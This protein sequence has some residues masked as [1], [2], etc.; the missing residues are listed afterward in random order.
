MTVSP[1]RASR[2]MSVDDGCSISERANA[3]TLRRLPRHDGNR[4]EGVDRLVMLVEQGPFDADGAQRLALRGDQLGHLPVDMERV[5]R[6]HRF[7]PAQL[8]NA[9][10]KQR[11]RPERPRRQCE[12]HRDRGGMP[13]GSGKPAENGVPRRLVIEMKRLRIELAGK[14]QD[15]FPGDGLALA[16]KA[17]TDLQVVE[18]FNHDRTLSP[19]AF[20]F[21]KLKRNLKR[22]A[23]GMWAPAGCIITERR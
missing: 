7:Y 15:F 2:V 5:A 3:C 22:A 20:V 6:P 12:P 1:E 18:P 13:A 8:V 23:T 14:A 16:R 17:H 21:P 4:I 9:C 10:A 11:M 19:L